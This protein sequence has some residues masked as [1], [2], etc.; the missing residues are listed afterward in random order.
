MKLYG[1]YGKRVSR[2][3]IRHGKYK[4]RQFENETI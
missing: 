4:E 2:T 3:M 1:K